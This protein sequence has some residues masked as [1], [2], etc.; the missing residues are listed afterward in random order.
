MHLN[1]C[2]DCLIGKQNR[3]SFV[4]NNTIK[5]ME[6][7]KRVHSD[8]CSSMETIKPDGASYFLTFVDDASRKV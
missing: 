6:V 7:L 4:R 5:W 2:D 3:V 1:S 8:V